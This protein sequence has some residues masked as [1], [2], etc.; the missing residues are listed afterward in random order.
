MFSSGVLLSALWVDGDCSSQ[1]LKSGIRGVA[2]RTR[3]P[4]CIIDGGSRDAS[5]EA[6]LERVTGKLPWGIKLGLYARYADVSSREWLAMNSAVPVAI[7]APERMTPDLSTI[8]RILFIE[9]GSFRFSVLSSASL[10]PA[11]ESES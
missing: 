7:M 6:M 9:L 1:P 2:R 3:K 11:S 4:S 8:P 5:P 10:A